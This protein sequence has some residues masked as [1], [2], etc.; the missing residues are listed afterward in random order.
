M[1]LKLNTY[2]PGCS[3]LRSQPEKHVLAD[4]E[5][6]FR[7]S[8]L[9]Q[10]ADDLSRTQR[11]GL[12]EMRS[13][14]I[15]EALSNTSDHF[16]SLPAQDTTRPA[17]QTPM[18]GKSPVWCALEV[19]VRSTMNLNIPWSK[20]AQRDKERDKFKDRGPIMNRNTQTSYHHPR[21][22]ALDTSHL[23]SRTAESRFFIMR[24]RCMS[25]I[26]SQSWLCT[27]WEQYIC[28]KLETL[29]PFSQRADSSLSKYGPQ[30]WTV[31]ERS[32][33]SKSSDST[34]S[35]E[36]DSGVS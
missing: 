2:S 22:R 5:N 8:G 16:L 15:E 33:H 1:F 31:R 6:F 14:L 28:T 20:K 26:Q 25:S 4:F 24:S 35:R 32:L 10:I 27:R 7:S 18:T 30:I 21:G 12:N 19:H 13:S 9:Q 11:H 17:T 34:H 23:M 3:Y 36:A 29:C